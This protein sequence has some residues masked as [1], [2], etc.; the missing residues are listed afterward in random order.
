M[1]EMKREEKNAERK[2]KKKTQGE[3]AWL[4]IIMFCFLCLLVCLFALGSAHAF[5]VCHLRS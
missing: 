1:K 5:F 4:C 2:K 3:C